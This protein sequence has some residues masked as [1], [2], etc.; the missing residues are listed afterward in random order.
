MGI[1]M[2]SGLLQCCTQGLREKKTMNSETFQL[3]VVS[4]GTELITVLRAELPG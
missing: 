3:N 1:K 4:N 2:C